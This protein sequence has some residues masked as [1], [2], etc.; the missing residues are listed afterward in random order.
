MLADHL[1]DGIN[2]LISEP[3]RGAEQFARACVYFWYNF[4]QNMKVRILH[5]AFGIMLHAAWDSLENLEFV[6][7]LLKE[8]DFCDC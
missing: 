1:V 3:F 2:N 6:A 5:K 4:G 8:G 7:C